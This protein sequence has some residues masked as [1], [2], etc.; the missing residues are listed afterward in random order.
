MLRARA[1]RRSPHAETLAFITGSRRG[2]TRRR[3]ILTGSLAIGLVVALALS[4]L[5]YWQRGVAVQQQ[6]LAVQQQHL[7]EEQRA[8][9]DAAR[10]QAEAAR[11]RAEQETQRADRNFT[12][13]KDTVDKLIFDIAQGL[14]DVA[15]MRVDTI[16]KI[17]GTVQETIDQLSRTAPDD[18]QLLGSRMVMLN[19]FVETYL[20]ADD[21]QDAAAAAD[22]SLDIARKLAALDPGNA[23]AQRDLSVSLEKFGNVKLRGGDLAGALAAYQESLDIDRKLAAQRP[24]QRAGATRRG[25]EPGKARAT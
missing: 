17:L 24:R 3:N 16:R 19:N 5:A 13:A 1:V 20:A 8:A 6:H 18:P 10:A 7:A 2:A 4:G 23:Q 11:A 25:G 12:A 14:R 15:G 22:Q 9:A 21:L